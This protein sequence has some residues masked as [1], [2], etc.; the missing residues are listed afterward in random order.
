MAP[1]LAMHE[2]PFAPTDIDAVFFDL[3]GTLMATDD[4]MVGYWERRLARLRIRRGQANRLARLWL[5]LVES[6]V[7]FALEAM[8]FLGLDGVLARLMS[9]LQGKGKQLLFPPVDGASALID[10]LA[11]SY[12]LGVVSNRSEAEV[13]AFLSQAGIDG[14]IEFVVGRDSTWRVKPH[15]QPVHKAAAALGVP[16][17][18][19]LMVGDTTVDIRAARRAGAWAVGVLCGFGQRPELERA[20]AHVIV[21]HTRQLAELL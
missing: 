17:E 5:T 1:H 10:A 18:R 8:D 21:E 2:Q 16:I 20:G 13:R 14:K 3:D 9:L 6:P 15:P 7:N 4:G 12:R 11:D 19:C